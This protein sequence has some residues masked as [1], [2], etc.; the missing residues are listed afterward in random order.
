MGSLQRAIEIALEAHKN[1][2]DKAGALYILHPLRVMLA[3][4]S[5]DARI[6]GVL[7]DVVEDCEGWSFDRLRGEGFSETV[8][9]ELQSVT[10]RPDEAEEYPAFIARAAVNTIGRA[11]KLADL[12][13]NSDLSRIARP[14][15]KDEERVAKYRLAIAQ[16]G[17]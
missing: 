13:D 5:N 8:I 12:Y 7:H 14:T 15:A 16:L 4:E 9:E 1:Q 11:V 3:Q 6:V 2:T 17:G 10:K